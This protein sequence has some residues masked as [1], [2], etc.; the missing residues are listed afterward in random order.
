MYLKINQD[1]FLNDRDTGSLVCV[2][3]KNFYYNILEE[4][5]NCIILEFKYNNLTKK[6]THMILLTSIGTER[7]VRI[8]YDKITVEIKFLSRLKESFLK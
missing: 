8:D 4:Y 6:P 5:E 7:F 1:Y 3:S 2:K